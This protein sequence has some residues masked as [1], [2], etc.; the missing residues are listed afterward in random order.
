MLPIKIQCGCGQ[1]YAFDVE[2]VNGQMPYTVACP[3]C[4]VDGTEAANSAL[5]QTMGVSMMQAAPAMANASAAGAS[6]GGIAVAPPPAPPA[7]SLARIAGPPPGLA[8]LAAPP[9]AAPA[10]SQPAGRKP[11]LPGQITPEQAQIEGRAKIFWGDPPDEVKKFLMRNSVPVAEATALV[12]EWFAERASTIRK[13]GIK[14]FFT[15]IVLATV[16][17][18]FYFVAVAKAGDFAPMKLFAVTIMVGLYG[19]YMFVKGA[20]MFCAPK[21]E[22]GDVAAQ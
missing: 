16:P 10:Q 14:K 9:P 4:G 22:P 11:L 2:P 18:I 19:G 17:V 12:N 20:I 1:K 15:G 8:R 5:A 3:V 21:S 7:P 13:N 6:M